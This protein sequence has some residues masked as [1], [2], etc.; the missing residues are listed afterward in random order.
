M[1]TCPW[2]QSVSE[3][4]PRAQLILTPL[5][6]TV[7]PLVR[8][9][10]YRTFG[11]VAGQLAQTL[12]LQLGVAPVPHW[13]HSTIPPQPSWIGPHWPLMHSRVQQWPSMHCCCAVQVSHVAPAVPQN[14]VLGGAWQT[15]PSQHPVGQFC[16]VHGQGWSGVFGSQVPGLPGPP[17][18]QPSG[19]EVASQTHSPVA[20]QRW[21]CWQPGK[22]GTHW[23][24]VQKPKSGS[25][26]HSP[27]PSDPPQHV[28]FGSQHVNPQH[29]VFGGGQQAPEQQ[30]PP[31]SQHEPPQQL[32]EQQSPFAEHDPPSGCNVQT[33]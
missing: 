23:E 8:F 19:H 10:Q 25:R 4:Q 27:N 24:P 28:A 5:Q 31:A 13:P 7:A 32:P 12:S 17:E 9:R 30:E 21:P 22:Q 1:Q 2:S 6:Q 15:V 20:E 16:G 29:L 33:H 14:C 18:Q 11:H 26:Q 3:E